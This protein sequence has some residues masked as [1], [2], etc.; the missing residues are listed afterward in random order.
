MCGGANSTL[1]QQWGLPKGT[2]AV[3]LTILVVCTV[4]F[5]LDGILNALSKIG[6]LII[7]MIFDN[8]RNYS[9]NRMA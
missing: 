1:T 3:G 8:R 9:G 7:V 6:P 4:I 5:G 2:G